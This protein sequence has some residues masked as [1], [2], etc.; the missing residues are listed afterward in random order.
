MSNRIKALMDMLLYTPGKFYNVQVM[1]F[2]G[3]ASQKE[4]K[5]NENRFF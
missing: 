5:A 2:T 1:A 3:P 4:K